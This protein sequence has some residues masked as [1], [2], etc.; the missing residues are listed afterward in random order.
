M[1]K[2]VL[3]LAM[4]GVGAV[5]IMA[6]IPLLPY[7]R[8]ACARPLAMLSG[9]LSRRQIAKYIVP[10]FC[11]CGLVQ[12]A[13]TKAKWTDPDT[14]YT[15]SYVVRG[16]EAEIF[17]HSDV[18]T[19][20]PAISPFPEGFVAIPELLGG[21]CV[22]RIGDLAFINCTDMTG[23][24]IPDTVASI[25]Y[26]AFLWCNTLTELTIP[27]SV[28]NIGHAAFC[29]C[30]GLTNIVFE[31]NAPKMGNNVFDDVASGCCA[32][33]RRNSTG[34][35]V[36][37]PGTWQGIRIEYYAPPPL[38]PPTG[39]KYR[40]INN[41][42]EVE[43]Y[44]IP[45]DTVG[46]IT[47]PSS[48]GG[49]PVTSI[50]DWSFSNCCAFTSITIPRSVKR[51]GVGAFY[52]CAGLAHVE[53]HDNYLELDSLSFAKCEGLK[54]VT[55]HANIGAANDA[56][57]ASG[58]EVVHIAADFDGLQ[59]I[60][61]SYTYN[62]VYAN[63]IADLFHPCN[64]L[65]AF[66]VERGNQTFKDVDG[67]L[68]TAD[69]KTLVCC[70]AGLRSAT[71][72]ASVR[73]VD[74][75]AFFNCSELESIAIASG[76]YEINWSYASFVDCGSLLSFYVADDNLVYSTY[77]GL[78]LSKDGAKLFSSVNGAVVVPYGVNRIE[79]NAFSGRINLT[80]VTI[81]DGVTSIGDW[82]FEEC[83]GLTN[84]VIGSGVTSIGHYAFYGCDGLANVYCH[85][86]P[87]ALTWGN[88]TAD[89]KRGKATTI[90]VSAA[91]LSAYESKFGSMVNATFVG[92]LTPNTFAVTFDANG[93]K[94]AESQR[95]IDEGSE[96]GKLPTPTRI[97]YTFAGWWT[98]KS[99]GSMITSKTKVTKVV[100]VYARWT[101]NK[102]TIKFNVNGGKGT[103]KAL[104][105]TYGKSV[106]LTANAFKRSKHTF[107]GWAKTKSGAVVY[108]NKASVK[109]LTATDGKTVALYAVWK[110]Y[111]YTV[112]FNANG[113]TGAAQRQEV[114]CGAK[115]KLA[116]NAYKREGFVFAGWATKRNGP[117]V[118]KNKASVKDLAK[119]G[120][121]ATLYAVWKPAKWAVGTFR[122]AGE[123]GGK[124]ATVTITVSSSGKISGKFVVTKGKKTYSFKAESFDGFSDGALRVTTPIKIGSKKCA[125]E[126][127]VG[128]VPAGSGVVTFGE[129]EATAGGRVYATA[130]L[131]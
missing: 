28:T 98:A 10:I 40:L 32:Y 103:M 107:L 114:V 4:L 84:V 89:F 106:K 43:I 19:P 16:D 86:D 109:N 53:L 101:A 127:A 87:A 83:S 131:Q 46:D 108:K 72:P 96:V 94:I 129:M 50:G 79:N 104:S 20:P 76:A 70:P 39:W 11:F 26:G 77:A 111:S 49:K 9:M 82:A 6:G 21:A 123:V 2:S 36:D 116:A 42:T 95:T 27:S 71:I 33:V 125:L 110:P 78:L 35:G 44:S 91:R 119:K 85:A 126:I 24:S 124:A 122:G 115:T 65:V 52:G 61:G 7:L 121:T 88:A 81:P 62:I 14:N 37:I 18:L 66:S 93:G 38:M 75:C 5:G 64:K 34:W 99:G 69:G 23:V 41:D 74:V 8:K 112:K 31:G 92:D 97:G 60:G 51:I 63:G 58:V 48:L 100:T 30:V 90:H 12:Y 29:S 15:W 3:M 1:S 47:I 73:I 130:F 57:Y 55:L 59:Y 118:Y 17:L 80:S 105:A 56:F 128:Q 13:A 120:E 113:G 45:C 54:S 25:G 22:T 67:L 68:L 117:V 102:Y